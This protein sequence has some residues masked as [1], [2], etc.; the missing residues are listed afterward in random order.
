MPRTDTGSRLIRATPQA[1]Y[2]ALL[3][4]EAVASWRPPAGMAAEIHHFEARE[5]GAFRMAFLYLDAA[6]AEQGK[7]SGNA[8]VFAGEF[9]EL[10]ANRKV[11][12]RIVFESADPAFDAPLTVTTSLVPAAGGTEVSV[13]IDNVPDAIGLADHQAGIV[14]SLANLAAYLER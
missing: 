6:D 1:I 10:V 8:D 14:S 13:T 12:E 4:P 5:G 3:D 11:V 2:R 7:T 9:V